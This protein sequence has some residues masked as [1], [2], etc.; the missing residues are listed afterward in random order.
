[1][2]GG[3]GTGRMAEQSNIMQITRNSDSDVENGRGDRCYQSLLD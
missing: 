1:M 3:K 2:R